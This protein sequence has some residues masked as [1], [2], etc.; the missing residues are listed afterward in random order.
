MSLMSTPCVFFNWD[1]C[2]F[3]NCDC[4]VKVHVG[5]IMCDGRHAMLAFA[6]I[7]AYTRDD[8]V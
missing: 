1:S 6:T 3:F 8:T 2:V 5:T 7:L 4:V